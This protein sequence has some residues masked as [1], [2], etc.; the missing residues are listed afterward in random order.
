MRKFL[1]YTFFI[2]SAVVW[3]TSCSTTK[4]A[5]KSHS[6]D[7]FDE[8]EYVEKVISLQKGWEAL[9]ARMTL[10]L[11]IDGRKTTKLGGTLRVKRGEVIQLSL[12]PFL[13]IEIGR[14][15]ISPE[16]MLVVDRVNKRYV[17]VSFEELNVL[18]KINLSYDLLQALFL[19]EMYVPGKDGLSERDFKWKVEADEVIWEVRK[20]KPLSCHYTTGISEG[21]LERSRINLTGTPYGVAWEYTD[22]RSLAQGLFPSHMEAVF[23]GSRRPLV[24]MIDLSRLSVN[25]D[26]ET[27]TQVSSKYEKVELSD[28]IKML[29]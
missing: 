28:L 19:N 29:F 23:E 13:G 7:G 1:A 4:N 17:R 15:E 22:F 27:H 11:N 26:W 21:R 16:G 20:N 25:N 6:I 3:L 12:A 5:K 9:T 18:S 14:A 8:A 10:E 2:L 24:A